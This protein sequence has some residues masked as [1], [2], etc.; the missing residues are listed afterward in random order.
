MGYITSQ[1]GQSAYDICLQVY[2]N[3]NNYVAFL[4]NNS[5]FDLNY[6][7]TEPT[8]FVFDDNLAKKSNNVYTTAYNSPPVSDGGIF[9]DTFSFA[10]G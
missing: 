6:I 1:Y 10:F 2:G 7:C 9:D 4:Y 3:F 5:I 8:T